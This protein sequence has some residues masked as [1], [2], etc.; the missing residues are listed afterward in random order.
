MAVCAS[1]GQ[2]NPEV[3][4]FCL[5]CGLP[6]EDAEA[7]PREERRLVSV[8]FVDM[9]G[10]TSRAER[11]DPEEVQ[12]L[13]RPYHDAV[14]TEIESFGGVVEKFI[15][16]AVVGMFGA[17]TAYGDDAERAVRAALTVRDTIAAM[18]D[19]DPRL[20]LK[21]RIAVNTGEAL[22]TLN[23]RAALGESM[24]T[25]D[26]VNTAAR[27]QSAAPVGGV[28]AGEET[29]RATK[30]AILYAP[31][32]AVEAKGKEQPVPAWVALGEARKPGERTVAGPLVGRRH[33]L[34]VLRGTWERVAAENT[35]H[36][37]TVIGPA[38]VGKTRL[39]I[40]FGAMV[41]ERGGR[42]V[43]GRALPYRESTAYAALT[44]QLKQLCGIFETDSVETAT[45]KL[46]DAVST[47][48]PSAEARDVTRHLGILLGLDP[49]G[50]VADRESLFFSIRSFVEAV[51]RDQ[52]TMLV[53][54]DLH[55]GDEALLDLVELL[56]ARLRDLPILVLTLAR[57]ELLDARPGWGGGLLAHTALP[58]RPL[59]AND[60]ASLAAQRLADAGASDGA[61]RAADLAAVADGNPLFIEQLAAALAE[62][63]DPAASLPTTIREL[64][65]ARLDALPASERAVLLDAAVGGRV[66]WRGA[67]DRI[68]A[69]PEALT[70]CLGELE[71]R[72]LITRQTVSA[73]EGQQQYSF[74]HVLVRDVAYELLPRARRQERHRE[75]ALFLEEVSGEFGEAG[76]ALA[77]HWRD[78]GNPAHAVDYF[79][80]AAE[81]A[82]HGW[83]KERAASLYREALQLV[84]E[85]EADRRRELTRRIALA[86]TA[87][88]HVPDVRLLGRGG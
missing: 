54:E 40:E 87:G 71:R 64:I 66:F 6:L 88:Y 68:T 57:P 53:F 39:A 80:R 77:R 86:E 30:D 60:A 21:V 12:E 26:V 44:F 4:R 11:L 67:I 43:R 51:A 35:P 15:G 22:V 7:P 31:A 14:R 28:L 37:V 3:A 63:G 42:I 2:E 19:A 81:I 47:L 78:A 13:L 61:E 59:D 34:E 73:F 46:D 45:K 17:P 79:V 75:T 36:L 76:A 5:A 83:A 62:S 9:V 33:E 18:D 25:G 50:T 32:P 10:F 49:S 29:Y 72:E 69:D 1:C 85:D 20:D 24:V 56:A 55:W 84:P 52:P 41:K 65:A 58:L 23:A 48:L 16:D 38:G 82:E 70:T 8:I 27:L 74:N